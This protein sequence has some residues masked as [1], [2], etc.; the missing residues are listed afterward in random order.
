VRRAIGVPAR[1]LPLT[2]DA[3]LRALA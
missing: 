1:D 3:I 2:R